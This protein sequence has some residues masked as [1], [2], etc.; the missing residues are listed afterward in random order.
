MALQQADGLVH[1]LGVAALVHVGA[2]VAVAQ[3]H[4]VVEAGS[5]LADVPGELLIAGGQL[6][7]RPQGVQDAVGGPPAAVGAEVAGP[8]LGHPVGQGEL[9][10]G[11]LHIQPDIGVALVVLEQ[12]VVVGLVALDE[13]VFQ[14]EGL[15]LAV[16]HDDVKVV[17]RGHHGPGL[18]GVGG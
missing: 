12:D 2:A 6:Q 11:G 10:I 14:N 9:G 3:A 8:V 7:R 15:E 13:G 4:V 1:G 17:D 5:L 18:L 16:G